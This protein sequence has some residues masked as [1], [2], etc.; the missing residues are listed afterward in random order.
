MFVL[1]QKKCNNFSVFIYKYEAFSTHDDDSTL[2]VC[3]HFRR[4]LLAA[5]DKDLHEELTY[6]TKVIT[7]HPKNYQVW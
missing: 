6:I 5:M 1:H 4:E 2:S 7:Q 3:R